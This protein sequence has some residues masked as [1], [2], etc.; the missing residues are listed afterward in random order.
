MNPPFPYALLY[1]DGQLPLTVEAAFQECLKHSELKSHYDRLKGTDFFKPKPPIIQLVDQSTG[2]YQKGME[3][4]W[5][6]F[7]MVVWGPLVNQHV[8][9]GGHLAPPP[10]FELPQ[11]MEFPLRFQLVESESTND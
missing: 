1:G 2:Y 9:Q 5:E 10:D 3:E 11:G 6:F 8:L 7:L 4:F